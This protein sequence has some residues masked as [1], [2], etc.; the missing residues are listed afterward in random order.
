MNDTPT[1]ERCAACQKISPVSFPV[2]NEIWEAVIHRQFENSILCLP[3]F[4][5]RADEK[6]VAWDRAIEL[7][8]VSLFTHLSRTG[9][10]ASDGGKG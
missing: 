5:S 4:I 9:R 3:C 1:R 10:L 2:S 7:F 6:L 8:P